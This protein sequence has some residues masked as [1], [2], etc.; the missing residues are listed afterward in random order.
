LRKRL[1]RLQKKRFLLDTNVFIAAFKS[2]YTKTTHLILKLLS[3]PDIE[4]VVNSI[5]L[6]EYKSWLN[7]L[8]SRLPYIK[9][10]AEILYALIISK[11]VLIEPDR[12]HIEQCKPFIPEGEYADLYHAATC[13]K[14]NATLITNDKDFN[15]IAE[16]DI[17]KVWSVTRA[18]RELLKEE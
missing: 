2:G 9:E 14:A 7:K 10:Q 6:E 17:I 3:D 16:T 12:N 1:I 11:A 4:L 18:I 8:S 5:L 13:L 15:R